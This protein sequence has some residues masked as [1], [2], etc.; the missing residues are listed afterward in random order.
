LKFFNKEKEKTFILYEIILNKKYDLLE[1]ICKRNDMNKNII[2]YDLNP[3]LY[4]KTFI[5]FLINPY[6]IAKATNDDKVIEIINNCG[7]K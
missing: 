3:T 1:N 6:L 5:Y 2:Y 4:G 7:L